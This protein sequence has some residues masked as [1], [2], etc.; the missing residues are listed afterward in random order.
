MKQLRETAAEAGAAFE[1]RVAKAG[2]TA[3]W[4]AVEAEPGNLLA[5]H[6]RYADL[7]VM[8]Q[9]EPDSG[10][11]MGGDDLPDRVFLDVG[12]PVLMIP[13]VAEYPTIGKRIMIAWDGS[14]TATRAVHD[15]LPLMA[16]AEMVSVMCINPPSGEFGLGDLPGADIAAHLAR[17]GITAE[18]DH[19][20]S[21]DVPVAAMLESRAADFGADLLVMGAYGHARVRE[22]VLGGVTRSILESMPVPVL[23]S[24]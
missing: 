16:G 4:R 7:V 11:L 19:V 12:R 23:M 13:Y 15:A 18:A 14:R 22:M 10:L 9:P 2:I 5:A 17:H 6:G 8:G 24:H 21:K 3:E 1:K 20:V